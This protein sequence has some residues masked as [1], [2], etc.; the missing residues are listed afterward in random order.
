ME[1][2]ISEN[3]HPKWGYEEDSEGFVVDTWFQDSDCTFL[4]GEWISRHSHHRDIEN[5][6]F[7]QHPQ[8]RNTLPTKWNWGNKYTDVPDTVW[9]ILDT[10]NKPEEVKKNLN[11]YEIQAG[12]IKLIGKWLSNKVFILV[13]W[14]AI[15]IWTT[16]TTWGSSYICTFTGVDWTYFW[17]IRKQFKNKDFDVLDNLSLQ[18]LNKELGILYPNDYPD[19]IQHDSE[20]NKEAKWEIDWISYSLSSWEKWEWKIVVFSYNWIRYS[21]KNLFS[22]KLWWKTIY[23]MCYAWADSKTQN[24]FRKR[25]WASGKDFNDTIQKMMKNIV[26]ILNWG[27]SI[28]SEIILYLQSLNTENSSQS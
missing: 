26:R 9:N 10:W 8:V 3:L 14:E 23:F 5:Y 21:T 18:W 1:R 28:D 25:F 12:N 7:S 11:P 20:K 13:K 27:K 4:W 16:N 22:S 17:W 6:D 15:H 19:Q 24:A 2:S